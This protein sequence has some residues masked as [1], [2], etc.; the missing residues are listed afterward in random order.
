MI[1]ETA[2]V[3][4]VAGNC[5][6]ILSGIAMMLLRSCSKSGSSR[7]GAAAVNG[8]CGPLGGGPET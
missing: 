7:P 3:L 8:D 2:E 6:P 4:V 5:R 1:A